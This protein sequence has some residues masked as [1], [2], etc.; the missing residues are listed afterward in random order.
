[1]TAPDVSRAAPVAL[2]LSAAALVSIVLS[3][4]YTDRA[5]QPLP[6]DKP[7]IG[8]G[9]T[10]RPDGSPVRSGDRT[11]PPEALQRALQDVQRFEGALRQC[12]SVPLA[13]HE[14][15]TYV[16][17]S[18]NVGPAAF[19][20]S[21]LV[22]RLNAGDYPGACSEILRWRFFQGRDCADP[23]AGCSGLA[24]RRQAEYRMCTGTVQTSPVAPPMLPVPTR[25]APDHATTGEAL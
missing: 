14:Y 25:P 4:G 23:K 17:L 5:V 1:M 11:T 3:E 9:S 10:T 2:A 7:T 6:G 15:D 22:K 18:Y 21:T 24:T 16:S 19:C 8:F 20:G 13:Q 12:V